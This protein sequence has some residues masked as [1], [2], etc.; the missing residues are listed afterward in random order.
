MRDPVSKVEGAHV[1]AFPHHFKG[2]RAAESNRMAV[3]LG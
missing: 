1:R 2:Q 3:G